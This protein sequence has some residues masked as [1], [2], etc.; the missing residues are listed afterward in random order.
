MPHSHRLVKNKMK[1]ITNKQLVT[2]LTRE[3]L[4]HAS[5]KISGISFQGLG[6]R[7]RWL[8]CFLE[9]YCEIGSNNHS[10]VKPQKCW[11][12][13]HGLRAGVFFYTRR[14]GGNIFFF[15]TS[16]HR[17]LFTSPI[18]SLSSSFISFPFCPVLPRK[19]PPIRHLPSFSTISVTRHY[20]PEAR[21]KFSQHFKIPWHVFNN[22]G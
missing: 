1:K 19:H 10:A 4:S 22:N 9:D 8:R 6:H 11:V 15:G 2:S 7:S 16:W 14:G 12:T 18:F 17:L 20:I 21:Y 13:C 5:C 3:H